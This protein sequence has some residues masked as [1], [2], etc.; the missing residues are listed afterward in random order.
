VT[1][2]LFLQILLVA[3]GVAVHEFGHLALCRLSGVPVHQVVLFRIGA[4]AG[5]VSHA[6]PRLLRQ[7]LVISSGPLLVSSTLAL[8]LFSAAARFFLARPDPW[9]TVG[10]LLSFWLGWSIALEAWPSGG[11]ASALRRSAAVQLRQ[12]NPGAAIALPIAVGLSWANAARRVG[13]HWLY[14]AVLAFGAL[15]LTAW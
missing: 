4:P 13:W 10:L 7:H 12:L 2:H 14:A 9:W 1:I 8:L 3:P 6:A 11:D 5:F 15:R